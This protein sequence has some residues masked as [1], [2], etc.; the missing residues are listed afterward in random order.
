MAEGKHT[1]PTRDTVKRGCAG[2][3]FFLMLVMGSLWGAGLGVFVWVLEDGKSTIATLEEFRPNIGSKVFSSDGELLGQF[4]IE[5]RQLVPLNEMPLHLIKAFVA[6][7]DHPFYEHKG[8]RPDAIINA[9]I[10]GLRTGHFRGGSTITQ[11]VV[12]NVKDLSVGSERTIQRKIREAVVA[13]QVEREFTKDEIL[14]LYLNQIFLGISAYGVEA[15]SRQ[16]Y[17]KSCRDL[18]LGEAATLAGLTRAPNIQE[19]IHNPE[20]ALARRNIVLGQ[21]L[22][23]QNQFITQEEY[24]AAMA[25]DLDASVVT[26]EERIA[27]EAAGK[28]MWSPARFK[29]P[30]FVEEVRRMIYREYDREEVLEQGMEI[31]TTVDMHI[32]RAA[33]KALLER[34]EYFD[35]NKLAWLT[36]EGREDE[37]VPVSGALVCLDNRPGYEGF[38]RAMVGGRDFD[39]IKFNSATQAKRLVGSSIKPFVW[40]AAVAAGMTPS[41]VIVDAPFERVDAI[42][43]VW[44][45][46]NFDGKFHGPMPIRYALE[47]S[48]NTVSIRLVEQL[49][50]PY[51]R[52]YLQSCGIETDVQGLTIALG[53]P[54]VSVLEL[55]SAYATFANNG[56]LHSPVL[57]TEIKDR[58]GLVR[59]DHTE[60]AR[61]TEAMRED[62][63]FVVN[64]MLQGVATPAGGLG[65]QPTAWRTHEIERPRGGKTGTTN[66]HR[67][68]WFAGFTREFTCVVWVGYA[69]NRPLGQGRDRDGNTFTGG[70]QAAPVWIEFMKAAQEGMAPNDFPVPDNIEFFSINRVRGNLGGNYREAYIKGTRPPET[71]YGDIYQAIRAVDADLELESL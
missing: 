13:L 47:R 3:F 40:A 67:D 20:N 4:T 19:P 71:W 58:D 1:P 44:R 63:A 42:G 45:P 48:I 32:Q 46:K 51:V 66:D 59:Y 54:Q 21:M 61:T 30:Y 10:T 62:V 8:V 24:D 11:Q 50:V 25:E 49:G 57:I 41:T 55:C 7:E 23:P 12:R 38:V 26:P 9:A 60:S 18:T 65:Y 64:H 5:E 27:L 22:D 68:A 2:L 33:E 37:F 52:S 56:K 39:T 35:E 70:H 6:T 36:R 29:A 16:Y 31:Y 28:G 34:L 15:A 17:S 43:R 69:D 14:E 53:T